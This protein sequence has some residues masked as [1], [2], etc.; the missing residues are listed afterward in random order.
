MII[1]T[2]LSDFERKHKEE[3]GLPEGQDFKY[4]ATE[5]NDLGIIWNVFYNM[6]KARNFKKEHDGFEME[7]DHNLIFKSKR[8]NSL[9]IT[10]KD[11]KRYS[12]HEKKTSYFLLYS[13]CHK[14][15]FELVTLLTK[16]ERSKAPHFKMINGLANT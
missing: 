4:Y 2:D 8:Y 16:E 1:E 5:K 7:R 12:N 9:Q 13:N 10:I 3:L 14:Y 6:D 15:V 11:L